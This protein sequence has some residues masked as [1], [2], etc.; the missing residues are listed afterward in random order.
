MKVRSS[1]RQALRLGHVALAGGLLLTA[2][3]LPAAKAASGETTG[4]SAAT[5]TF[6]QALVLQRAPQADAWTRLKQG[7]GLFQKCI[8]RGFG[9]D[10]VG[11]QTFAVALFN[12]L[13]AGRWHPFS[14]DPGIA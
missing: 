2:L 12:R 10:R 9:Q 5:T 3:S 13:T 8:I 11:Q 6:W 7:F 1:R 4:T 14:L